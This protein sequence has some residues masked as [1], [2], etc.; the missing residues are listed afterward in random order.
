MANITIGQI[1]TAVIFLA[2]FITSGGVIL[3]FALKIIKGIISKQITPLCKSIQDDI[4]KIQSDNKEIHEE[5]KRNSLDTMRIAIC[6]C[7]LPLQERVDIG[8]RYIDAGGN[9]S[10]KV[11]VHTLEQRYEVELRRKER[12]NSYEDE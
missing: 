12:R 5:L 8:K 1:Q 2:T 7:E 9:G 3:G 11:L 4:S 6:S 10:V